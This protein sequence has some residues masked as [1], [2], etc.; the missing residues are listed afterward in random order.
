MNSFS[1]CSYIE[2]RNEVLYQQFESKLKDYINQREL[3]VIEQND[4]IA[5]SINSD[6]LNNKFL[7]YLKE[8]T[9]ENGKVDD[10]Q[11]DI[12]EKVLDYYAVNNLGG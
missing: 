12:H 4:N 6:I 7:D 1:K 3:K 10:I 11:S 8:R 5:R 9:Y 2:E